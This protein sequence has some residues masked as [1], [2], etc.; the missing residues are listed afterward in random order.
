MRRNSKRH[1]FRKVACGPVARHDLAE[2]RLVGEQIGWAMKQR[3]WNRQPGGGFVGLG[4]S[5]F[6]TMRALFASGSF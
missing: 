4:T 6:S 1:V 3:G 5:P 2:R